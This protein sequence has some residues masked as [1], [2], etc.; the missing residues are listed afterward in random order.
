MNLFDIENL[1]MY[2]GFKHV[3]LIFEFIFFNKQHC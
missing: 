3:N 2:T 1:K